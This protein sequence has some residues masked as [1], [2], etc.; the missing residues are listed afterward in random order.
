M[1]K[2][3]TPQWQRQMEL[4]RAEAEKGNVGGLFDPKVHLSKSW[5]T[6]QQGALTLRQYLLTNHA[7]EL[8]RAYIPPD[9]HEAL[10]KYNLQIE[11]TDDNHRI[12]QIISN[13]ANLMKV[14]G[15]ARYPWPDGENVLAG[16]MGGSVAMQTNTRRNRKVQDVGWN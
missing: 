6:Y 9:I 2:D 7:V 16:N 3:V 1:V 10:S 15:D 5:K 4:V 13:A 8:T 14:R 11:P 12:R